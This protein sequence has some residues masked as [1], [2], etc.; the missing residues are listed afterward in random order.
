MLRHH[1]NLYKTINISYHGK[2]TPYP[3]LSYGPYDCPLCPVKGLY[4][5]MVYHRNCLFGDVVVQIAT[6]FCYGCFFSIIFED[7]LPLS[8]SKV[9]ILM[10][11]ISFSRN[12]NKEIIMLLVTIQLIST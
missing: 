2:Y 3:M 4:H 12:E 10:P 1:E 6:M 7:F 8:Y 11:E 5:E 9:S